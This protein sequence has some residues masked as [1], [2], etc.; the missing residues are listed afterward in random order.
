MRL[1]SFLVLIAI[2]TCTLAGCGTEKVREASARR[3]PAPTKSE[4][5]DVLGSDF[6]GGTA[7]AAPM[8]A[9]PPRFGDESRWSEGG[10]TAGTAA[11]P[12]IIS[13]TTPSGKID[14]AKLATRDAPPMSPA[15]IADP[16]VGTAT[17]AKKKKGETLPSG[18]LTA[19]SFDDNLDPR[20]FLSF[21]KRFSH[22]PL[23]DIPSK[24]QG[25][26]LFIQVRDPAGK[27]VGGAKVQ[28]VATTGQAA[29]LGTRT[30]GRVVFLSSFDN[31]PSDVA[32]TATV[33]PPDGGAAVTER[34][35]AGAPRWEITL[36]ATTAKLPQN[37]DL[38]IVLDTTGSMGDE[39]KYVQAE[40]HG[41]SKAIHDRFPEVQQRFALVV[42][43]DEGDEYVARHFDFASLEVFHKKLS[44]QRATGGGDYPEAVHKGFEEANQLRWRSS[45][46]TARVMFWIADAPP[47]AQHMNRTMAAANAIRKQGVAMYPI[48][49]SGY[50]DACEVVM[51]SCA[52]LTGGQFLFLT[53]DSGVGSSHAEPKIPYYHVERL[54]KMMIRMIA[55]ELSAQ[56]IDV[57]PAD[58]IRT[59]G[60]KVN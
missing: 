21:L 3:S 14:E 7:D 16:V 29:E 51:R 53:D 11:L 28:V 31:L 1:L 37:L 20:V 13:G 6:G 19:G 41:I 48:A 12:G 2:V 46:D 49:C 24:L 43:R 9:T 26:R 27:P 32:L 35:D 33:T 56:R 47:H 58:I 38:A 55:S 59:V 5:H 57:N 30:D 39:L 50:D 36:P 42:Y 40:I 17:P 4:P 60:R 34:I 10:K 52:L 45:A 25:H 44:E 15:A 8:G 22:L 23:Q 54:E 18:V